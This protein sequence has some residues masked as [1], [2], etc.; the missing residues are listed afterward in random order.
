MDNQINKY[1]K[2]AKDFLADNKMNPEQVNI[3]KTCSMFLDEMEK[4]LSGTK[5]SLMMIP[6]YIETGADI[7]L[8]ESVIVL[9]AGGTNFRTA[10]VR[11]DK[12]GIP[13]ITKYQKFPMPGTGNEGNVSKID[14]FNRIAGFIKKSIEDSPKIGFCFSYPTKI[15]PSG[16]GKLIHFV[17]E[18]KAP[19]VEGSM[20]GENLL[21]ALKQKGM[22]N[23]KNIIILNDTVATLLAGMGQE[24]NYDSYIGFILG[25]GTNCSYI[26][27]NTNISK[28]KELNLNNN[29]TINMESGQFNLFQGGLLD[30]EFIAATDKPEEGRFEKMI[31]GAYQGPLAL[32]VL[33]KAAEVNLFS[34]GLKA[35][36]LKFS[37]LEPA[38]MD[39]FLN[40]PNNILN[41]LGEICKTDSDKIILFT[42]MD[43]LIERAAKLTASQLAA[44]VLKTGKGFDPTLPV[45][46]AADGTTFYK[47]RGLKFR[48]EFYLKDYLEN[49]KNRYIEFCHIEDAPLIGAAV[50][51]LIQNQNN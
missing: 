34:N 4:G 7:P 44:V 27:K 48:T 28:V 46:I 45:C 32:L 21:K 37:Q 43:Q 42:L 33:K 49:K 8:G 12:P 24:K 11:F 30:L 31:S 1:V 39:G 41:P 35:D 20:I 23:N 10:T 22:N 16:D 5:S 18:V 6:T 17:K 15:Y 13:I 25:T 26:E 29:Q 19:E 3:D 14:F 2:R 38:I 36:I 40:S 51:G 9:D 47:T 50:A